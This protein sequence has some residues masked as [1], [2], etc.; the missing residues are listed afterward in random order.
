MSQQNIQQNCS[1][2]LKSIIYHRN[3][4][5][6]LKIKINNCPDKKYYKDLKVGIDKLCLECY[7]KIVDSHQCQISTINRNNELDNSNFNGN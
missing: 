2:C 4:T 5:D 1:I 6:N 7:M 3:I